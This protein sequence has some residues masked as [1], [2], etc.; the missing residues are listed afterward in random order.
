MLK[1]IAS[2]LRSRLQSEVGD[3][4]LTW[5]QRLEQAI[6][7]IPLLVTAELDRPKTTLGRMI[8][9]QKNDVFPISAAD[10]VTVF[11]EGREMF[12]AEL[13]QSGQFAAVEMTKRLKTKL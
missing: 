3:D 1:P 12:T 6:L 4:D 2:Q 11:V 5:K 13:G 9:V 10:G 8:K 7:S